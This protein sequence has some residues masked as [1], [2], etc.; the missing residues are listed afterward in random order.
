[1][2]FV[3]LGAPGSGKGTQAEVL[4]KAYNMEKISVGDILREEVKKQS[5]L[6]KKVENFMKQGVLVPD[7]IIEEVMK[8]KIKNTDN[9]ILDGFP[10]NLKQAEMLDNI[11]KAV[12]KALTAV[13]Y[14]DISKETILERLGGRRVCSVCGAVYHI[15]NMP[16]KQEGICDKCGGKLVIRPDDNEDTINK[17]WQVYLKESSV[18]IDFYNKRGLLFKVDANKDKD[19]VFSQIDAQI[20]KQ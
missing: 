1:M 11:L 7:E 18:L 13:I 20:K 16:P 4:A 2:I 17:R 19:D 5:E 8:E 9:L 10:R 3:L 6:G 15:K 12:G 14:F